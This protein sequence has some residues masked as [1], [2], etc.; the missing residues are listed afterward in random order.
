MTQSQHAATLGTFWTVFLGS[1]FLYFAFDSLNAWPTLTL[2]NSVLSLSLSL[3]G[4]EDRRV[5]RNIKKVNKIIY[6]TKCMPFVWFSFTTFASHFFLCSL[7]SMLLLCLGLL[8]FLSL[9]LPLSALRLRMT[10]LFSFSQ[11]S[12]F[13]CLFCNIALLTLTNRTFRR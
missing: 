6:K 4:N 11:M 1:F 3:Q 13:V 10:T 5:L 7:I 9:F 2:T 8:F 12:V